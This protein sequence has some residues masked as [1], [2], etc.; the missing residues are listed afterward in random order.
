MLAFIHEVDYVKL[1]VVECRWTPSLKEGNSLCDISVDACLRFLSLHLEP[2]PILKGICL[3]ILILF[4]ANYSVIGL[5]FDF[6]PLNL[7]KHSSYM[8]YNI[9]LY[10]SQMIP[11]TAN[12]VAFSI[13]VVL[14]TAITLFQIVIYEVSF[15]SFCRCRMSTFLV[16]VN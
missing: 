10:F 12:D 6:V 7:T 14:L 8:I 3:Q 15:A 11:V 5:N 9:C 4:V 2:V 1:G 16:L 13:H